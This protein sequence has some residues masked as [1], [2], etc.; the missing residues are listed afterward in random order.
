MS[1]E[2]MLGPGPA[3]YVEQGKADA[4]EPVKDLPALRREFA[5]W[6][7]YPLRGTQREWAKEHGLAEETL[8]R[9]KA[10][11]AFVSLLNDWRGRAK[12]AIPAMLAAVIA[13]VCRTGDPHAYRAVMESLGESKQEI[14]LTVSQ[15]FIK[16]QEQLVAIRTAALEA[17][18]KQQEQT[19]PN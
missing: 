9:W 14:D 1:G 16:L 15:P 18:R 12:I 17:E 19:R 7:M 11:P 13:R 6:L 10:D 4:Q 2:L 5:E 8:S 3:K